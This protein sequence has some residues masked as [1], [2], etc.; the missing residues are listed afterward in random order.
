VS[1]SAITSFI[2]PAIMAEYSDMPNR[3]ICQTGDHARK[4]R[5]HASIIIL[6]SPKNLA[7]PS[8]RHRAIR[9]RSEVTNCSEHRG[10]NA[11]SPMIPP[12]VLMPTPPAALGPLLALL[13]GALEHGRLH[14]LVDWVISIERQAPERQVVADHSF[15][16]QNEHDREQR[17]DRRQTPKDLHPLT[18]SLDRTCG[19]AASGEE[20]RHRL[21]VR[22][23]RKRKLNQAIDLYSVMVDSRLSAVC[24]CAFRSRCEREEFVVEACW[25]MRD[26]DSERPRFVAGRCDHAAFA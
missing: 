1:I 8:D 21:L 5:H 23:G 10:P 7:S 19:T 9:A 26:M 11:N 24:R 16:R 12:L 20:S 25:H 14:G 15:S 4:Q 6:G 22:P 3:E 17:G 18:P 13:S 2:M